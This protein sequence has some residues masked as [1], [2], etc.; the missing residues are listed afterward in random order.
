MS[1]NKP[2]TVIKSNFDYYQ[3]I[4]STEKKLVDPVIIISKRHDHVTRDKGEIPLKSTLPASLKLEVEAS[5]ISSQDFKFKIFDRALMPQPCY[6]FDS[7]GEAHNNLGDIPLQERQVTTPHFHKFNES[8]VEIA[9]KTAE[10][11]KISASLDRKLGLSIFAAEENISYDSIPD[12]RRDE[13]LIP[14]E[15]VVTDPL[16]GEQF[17]E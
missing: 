9:Y 12:I 4:A 2:N 14:P 5:N 1:K 10:L 17:Y 15:N 13:E 3:A 7:D 16:Q 11:N 6:R 8:G